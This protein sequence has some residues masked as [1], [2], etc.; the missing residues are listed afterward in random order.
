[1]TSLAEALFGP[2]LLLALSLLL[3]LTLLR[4]LR[5]LLRLSGSDARY[6]DAGARFMLGLC[7]GA[8]FFSAGR[9]ALGPGLV[10]APHGASSLA[11]GAILAALAFFSLRRGGARRSA[12]G[13][14]STRLGSIIGASL[15]V[16][17]LAAWGVLLSSTRIETSEVVHAGIDAA[18]LR[19]QLD[20]WDAN[21][22]LALGW[23]ARGA[24][25][26][27]LAMALAESALERGAPFDDAL[28]L[29]IEILAA[30]ER[31]DEANAAFQRGL[32]ERSRRA[33]DEEALLSERLELGGYRL[34]PTYISACGVSPPTD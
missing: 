8:L 13:S 30:G 18:R 10:D 12:S 14:P 21:A 1:M 6:P 23:G 16:A 28:E 15:G 3:P 34:P 11:F 29:E 24:E 26:L 32:E 7:V 25:E 31:C 5:V 19:L 4:L 22:T 20:P 27:E 17:L 9:R 33:F 2:L